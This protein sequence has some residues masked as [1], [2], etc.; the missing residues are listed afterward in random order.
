MLLP[1]VRAWI[2][3]GANIGDDPVGTVRNAIAALGKQPHCRLE[4]ESRLYRTAPVGITEDGAAQPDYINAVVRIETALGPTLLLETLLAIE[5]TFGRT[6]SVQNAPRTLDLD[7]LLYADRVIAQSGLQVPHARMHTRAFVLA[8]LA[9]IDADL[10][11]PGKGV[12]RDL[13]SGVADQAIS[14]I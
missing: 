11:I 4:V 9:E 12:V 13:L 7:L 2:G 8:P 6:R 3:I 10:T 1:T 5:K 14:P